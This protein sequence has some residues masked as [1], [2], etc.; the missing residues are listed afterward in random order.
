VWAANFQRAIELRNRSKGHFREVA[1]AFF[2][3]RISIRLNGMN[4]V[5]RFRP[6]GRERRVALVY[7]YTVLSVWMQGLYLATVMAGH[8]KTS[9]HGNERASLPGL[10]KNDGCRPR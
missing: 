4:S 5:L 3:E 2:V 1:W 6:A 9:R 8:R 10:V 7:V